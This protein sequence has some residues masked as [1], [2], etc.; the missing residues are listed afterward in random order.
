MR[1]YNKNL[2]KSRFWWVKVRVPFRAPCFGFR[3]FPK[4]RGS[5]FWGPYNKDPAIQ[6]T[7]NQRPLSSETTTRILAKRA[8]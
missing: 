4:I 1:V 7:M 2:Q 5:L 3:E 8:I 6:G